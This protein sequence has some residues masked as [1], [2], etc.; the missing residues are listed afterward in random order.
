MNY[1]VIYIRAAVLPLGAL[2]SLAVEEHYYLIRVHRLYFVQLDITVQALL[3]DGRASSVS[4]P[5]W[6]LIS[7]LR[8]R[9]PW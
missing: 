5:A 7:G 4:W 1:F 9:R 6:R 8:I 3:F 2:W